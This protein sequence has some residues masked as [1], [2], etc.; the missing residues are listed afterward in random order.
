VVI[1]S[2]MVLQHYFGE[3]SDVL[4]GFLTALKNISATVYLISEMTDPSS[5][6]DEYYLS[7]G[8]VFLHNFLDRDGTASKMVRGVQV[9]KMRGRE[10]DGQIK[11]VKFQNDGIEMFPNTPVSP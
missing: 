6:A 5:Y 9:I 2:T 10:V 4:V 11:R 8:V 1:D 7:H 3:D